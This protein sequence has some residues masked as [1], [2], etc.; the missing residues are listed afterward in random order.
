MENQKT[1]LKILDQ[2]NVKFEGLDPHVRR[3]ICEA[4]KFYVPYAR[5]MPAFKLGRWD[6][7]VSFATVGGGTYLN[8][9]DRVLPLVLDAGYEI[10]ID[11]RRPAQTFAFPAVSEDM[12]AHIPWPEGHP[13]AGQPI[14]LRD[15]QVEAITRYLD[16][17]QCL[18]SISTGAGKTVLSATLSM[19]VEPYG[20]S[21]CIV[22]SKSLVEQTEEDYRNIGL[23]VGVFFGDRKEWGK[24]HTIC[25]WQSLSVFSKKTKSAEIEVTIDE[26]LRDV[27]CVIVDECF[28]GDTPILTPDGWRP[29]RD[30]APG[31]RVI[32]FDERHG[33]LKEDTVVR[34]HENL[35]VSDGEPML[36]L[37]L[38]NGTTLRVTA[39]H[40]FLTARGW[41]RADEITPA[42]RIE[43]GVRLLARQEVAKPERVYNLHVE[44]DHNYV[45]G[46]AVVANCHSAKAEQLRELLAGP[47]ADVP[48]RWGMTGTIPK[49]DFEYLT[50]LS[51]IGPVMGEVRAADLQEQGVLARCEVEVTQ[52][53]DDHVEFRDYHAEYDFLTSDRERLDWIA[54]YCAKVAESGNTLI[55]VDRIECGK[56]LQQA[57]PDSVFING[58]VKTKDRKKE[59]KEVQTADGKIIIATYGVAAVGINIPRIFNL[60]LLEPGKSFVRVIQSIGRGIR[61]AE[62]K[63]FVRIIDLC[64][65]L[66]FSSRHLTKR[67]QFY[68]EADY[69]FSITKVPYRK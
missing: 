45:A 52:L 29:I 68:R 49:E 2:I 10:D 43:P 65:S 12:L 17:P 40:R 18:Q 63:D 53:V 58:N 62:D 22:P 34:R 28:D 7:K 25:T 26:F 37:T 46:G 69:P 1:T 50:L 5:H 32:N 66:K 44:H 55:L 30:L 60:V 11:D 42:D 33:G 64:S 39:N 6:G 47:F 20:R 23:D 9:L 13:M 35:A 4:L 61:K 41:V 54:A 3:K 14:M 8:L 51:T 15:Y 31:D 19:L 21:V 57:I 27:T 24:K 36:A 56:T 38:D 16:N 48:L 67:K 59:Y